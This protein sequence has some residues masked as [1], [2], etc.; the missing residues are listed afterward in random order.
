LLEAS[1]LLLEAPA[2]L[3]MFIFMSSGRATGLAQLP[4]SARLMNQR[5]TTLTAAEYDGSGFV[6]VAGAIVLVAT[7]YPLS[8]CRAPAIILIDLSRRAAIWTKS[9]GRGSR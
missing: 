2:L 5:V 3:F 8:I 6:L 7:A 1:A 9:L 4:G